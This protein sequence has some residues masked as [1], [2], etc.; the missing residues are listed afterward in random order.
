MSL[1]KHQQAD[2][3]ELCLLAIVSQMSLVD[4][5]N[6]HQTCPQW[7]HRVREIN[8]TIVKSLTIASPYT[9]LNDFELRLNEKYN[10][11][12]SNRHVFWGLHLVARPSK[13][14]PK[15]PLHRFTAWNCLQFLTDKQLNSA[16]V[17]QIMSAFPQLSELIYCNG[18]SVPLKYLVEMLKTER[19]WRVHL[20]K[21]TVC[22]QKPNDDDDDDP[23]QWKALFDSINAL[24]F[25]QYL[26]LNML[27]MVLPRELPI[28]ARLKEIS[29]EGSMSE[30]C[31]NTF[32]HSFQKYTSS[33]AEKLRVSLFIWDCLFGYSMISQL[34]KQFRRCFTRLSCL[35][36]TVDTFQE[37]LSLRL[38]T[39][40]NL[41]LLKLRLSGDTITQAFSVLAQLRQLVQLSLDVK[42]I[43]PPPP[44]P[45]RDQLLSVKVLS[46]HLSLSAHSHLQ[47]LNL[48]VTMPNVQEINLEVSCALCEFKIYKIGTEYLRDCLRVQLRMLMEGTGLPS[49]RIT[50][51]LLEIKVPSD[52]LLCE[53]Q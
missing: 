33:N 48:P 28:L 3:P 15:F 43:D 51:Y 18:I 16:T 25:L 37:L 5:I 44:P 34:S 8:Q 27:P 32:L 12:I 49:H 38:T 14:Q 30:M 6:A 10:P 2:L 35:P 24:P 29:I 13:C 45:P 1:S 17:Q 41:T 31:L 47:W 39:F 52:E 50:C 40:P 26:T 46:L 36:F 9:L 4:R 23:L 19:K 21:L 7:Y 11:D 42:Y 20:T 53:K 22:S